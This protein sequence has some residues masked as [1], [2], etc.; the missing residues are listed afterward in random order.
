[1][2]CDFPFCE[3][4]TTFTGSARS[5]CRD[6]VKATSF[7]PWFYACRRA[8]PLRT[9]GRQAS[10]LREPGLLGIGSRVLGRLATVEHLLD[11]DVHV[12]HQLFGNRKADEFVCRIA[13]LE[14][15]K[16]FREDRVRC[17]EVRF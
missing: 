11:F 6:L 1:M 2:S 15:F 13:A 10:E 3:N 4:W 17:H 9:S 16:S 5:R 7:S 8:E 12:P 14:D